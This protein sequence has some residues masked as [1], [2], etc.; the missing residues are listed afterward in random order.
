[1]YVKINTLGLKIFYNSEDNKII[2]GFG[3]KC[4]ISITVCGIFNCNPSF[5]WYF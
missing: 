4:D 2:I 3:I 1:M 5:D